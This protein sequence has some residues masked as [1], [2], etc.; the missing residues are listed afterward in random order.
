MGMG[1]DEHGT[2]DRQPPGHLQPGIPE[3]RNARDKPIQFPYQPFLGSKELLRSEQ[4]QEDILAGLVDVLR[5]GLTEYIY[6]GPKA[7]KDIGSPKAMITT[8]LLSGPDE[9][10][11]Q[12]VSEH[13]VRCGVFH[14]AEELPVPIFYRPPTQPTKQELKVKT[15][16]HKGKMIGDVPVF[17]R[18]E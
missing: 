8:I 4:H 12:K 13:V 9:F 1:R 3:L 10:R 18:Q 17:E 15:Y 14:C 16:V 2:P 11:E 6:V 5:Y 7:T